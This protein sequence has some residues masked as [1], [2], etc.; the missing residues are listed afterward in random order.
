MTAQTLPGLEMGPL[1][2][3]LAAELGADADR[4]FDVQLLAGGRSNVSYRIRQDARDWVLRRPP[5]GNILPSAHD[6]RRE[7]RLLMGMT[8]AGFPVPAPLA[9]CEDADV[10]GVPF[11]VMDFVEGRVVA[12]AADA[13]ALSP[14]AAREVSHALVETL[15]RLH[16]IDPADAGLAD[17]GRPDGYLERQVRR[18]ADQWQ[19]TRTRELPDVDALIAWLRE[20]IPRIPSG[21]PSSIV[22]GDFRIDNAILSED[23][24]KVR[25]VLDWEMSTLGDPVSDLAISL[26]YWS[27]AGDGLRA[28]IDV[29]RGVTAGPGFLTRAELVEAYA[30]ASGLDLGHLDACIVLA[31]FK[32]AVIM[33]SIHKRT[34][35]GAQ[36][37]DAAREGQG[38]EAAPAALA[39][40]GRHVAE[41]GGIA[42]LSL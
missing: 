15:A 34:L 6:M 40:M 13:R 38:L 3:Y 27:E 36:L 18:W 1:A 16:A 19:R 23:H 14:A 35:E 10:L 21:L 39:R 11:L 30:D 25:A 24:A 17:L 37:G 32:L 8:T 7:H 26:V 2:G 33:E 29:A 4:P 5:L 20:R 41:G 28:E 42:A 31:C 12:D 9:L 22:H